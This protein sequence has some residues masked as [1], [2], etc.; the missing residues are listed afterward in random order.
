[1]VVYSGR[2]SIKHDDPQKNSLR[3]QR[4]NRVFTQAT[5]LVAAGAVFCTAFFGKYI[6]KERDRPLN[7]S[8]E[9]VYA[10]A[11]LDTV[12]VDSSNSILTGSMEEGEWTIWAY[13]E[14]VI[15]KFLGEV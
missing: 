11:P 14:Y 3:K 5:A 9:A 2:K 8:F 6:G 10:M 15:S 4:N 1:M 12:S 7:H 13:L